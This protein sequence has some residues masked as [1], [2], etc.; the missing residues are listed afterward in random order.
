M[1]AGLALPPVRK[2]KND[3]GL[4]ERVQDLVQVQVQ[5]LAPGGAQVRHLELVQVPDQHHLVLARD[6]VEDALLQA[7]D[8]LDQ[9]VVHD[10]AGADG[11]ANAISNSFER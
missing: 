11:D 3:H 8:Y 10:V 1:A 7:R 9:A 6:G 5:V 2:Q 4:V